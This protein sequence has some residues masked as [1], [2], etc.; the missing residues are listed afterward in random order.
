MRELCDDVAP[1][2]QRCRQLGL[3]V[4]AELVGVFAVVGV[5]HEGEP[6]VEVRPRLIGDVGPGFGTED[7]G[8]AFRCGGHNPRL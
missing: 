3:E 4:A 6:P 5:D 1:A 7:P 2:G 8:T